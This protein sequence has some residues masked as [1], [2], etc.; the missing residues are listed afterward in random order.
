MRNNDGI[1]PNYDNVVA[2]IYW[3]IDNGMDIISMSFGWT[4]P[5]GL[6][7]HEYQFLRAACEE[8]Y[9]SGII[10]VAAAGNAYTESP[11]YNLLAKPAAF[12]SVIGVG[13]VMQYYDEYI[14]WFDSHEGKESHYDESP[15]PFDYLDL[16]APGGTDDIYTTALGNS[17]TNEFGGTSAAAAH[18]AGVC[19]LILE[20][21]AKNNQNLSPGDVRYILQSSTRTDCFGDARIVNGNGDE[22]GY[23]KKYHGFG[24]VNAY[25]AIEYSFDYTLIDSDGDGLSDGEEKVYLTRINDPDSDGDGMPDGWEFAH[26]TRG[27]YL[28]SNIN[29]AAND[30]DNDGLTNL[31]EF[32]MLTNPVKSDTDDDGINDGDEVNTHFT[33]PLRPD[34][35]YDGLTDGWEV[36]HG[37]DPLDPADGSID[38]DGD[39]IGNG[40]ESSVYNTDY[41]DPDTDNDGLTDGQ[42]VYG[43]YIPTITGKRYTDPN[44][45]DTDNDGLTDGEEKAGFTIAGIGVRYTD[46]TNPDTDGDG[47]NDRVEV[48]ILLTDPR[49]TDTD[50]DGYTDYEEFCAGTDPKDPTDYPGSGGWFFP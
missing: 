11:A 31:E 22:N 35:D 46:P 47:L 25:D 20:N 18:V 8:A 5:Y 36:A 7:D 41:L 6:P 28:D 4:S 42:E 2:G 9:R 44:D 33:N 29:D 32:Q 37:Y 39:G 3:A 10:I 38:T 16:V 48:I 1:S 12:L 49:E 23:L 19:A 13:S 30:P 24:M 14:R 34:T 45:A 21:A 15:D 50:N 26:F 43:F 40:D 27:F 17:H